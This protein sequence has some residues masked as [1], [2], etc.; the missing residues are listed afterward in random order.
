[1]GH[2]LEKKNGIVFFVDILGF[3]ALTKNTLNLEDTDYAAWNIPHHLPKHDNQVLAATILVQFRNILLKH[4]ASF[5]NVTIAQLSDCAFVWSE[6]IRDVIIV[7]CNL[8]RE[9]VKE[10][11]LCRGGLS[12]GE[13]IETSQNNN[14]GRLILGEAVSNAARLEQS[15]AKG[16]RIMMSQEVP[17]ALYDY[18]KTFYNRMEILFQPFENPLD[19]KTYDELKWYYIPKMDDKI[20]ELRIAG[21]DYIINA[22]RERIKLAGYLRLHPRFSWN[23]KNKEGQ[24]HLISSIRFIAAN[25][26]TIFNVHHWFDWNNLVDKRSS[27]TFEKMKKRVDE[28]SLQTMFRDGAIWFPEFPE[29]E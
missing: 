28:E 17:G 10:G 7:A 3:A 26:R 8:M 1:M 22:T 15:G 13:I 20:P 29:P 14:L 18:D 16:M 12:C 21:N 24:T 23:A 27:V 4:Q 2:L 25:E 6:N 5:P 11:I 19:Y 9:C